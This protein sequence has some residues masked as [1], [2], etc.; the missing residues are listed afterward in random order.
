MIKIISIDSQTV[1]RKIYVLYSDT[2]DEVPS[3]SVDLAEEL[4]IDELTMGSLVYTAK[5]EIGVLKS[6]GSWEWS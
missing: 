1:D 2:K 6:D 5:L 4:G 3:S